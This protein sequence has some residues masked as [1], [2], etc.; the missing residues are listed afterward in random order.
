MP[1]NRTDDEMARQAFAFGKMLGSLPRI[2]PHVFAAAE[3]AVRAAEIARLYDTTIISAYSRATDF[4]RSQ[5]AIAAQVA[6]DARQWETAVSQSNVIASMVAANQVVALQ[7]TVLSY[8]ATVAHAQQ[9][10]A[11]L[12]TL[13]KEFAEAFR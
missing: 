4:S 1:H 8:V 7:Q 3:A 9:Q 11:A 6:R 12:A 10:V 5:A 2:D 13:P